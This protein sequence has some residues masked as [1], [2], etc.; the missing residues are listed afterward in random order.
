V[1]EVEDNTFK[2]ELDLACSKTLKTVL[3][4]INGVSFLQQKLGHNSYLVEIKEDRMTAKKI[5]PLCSY[6]FEISTEVINFY[7]EL[8]A[9]MTNNAERW[10]L[11]TLF[12]E[13]NKLQSFAQDYIEKKALSTPIS[14]QMVSNETKKYL[15]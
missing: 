13:L 14:T 2:I 4:D 6:V 1:I 3:V 7:M 10:C 12:G 5:G 9:A 8:N 15:G 11:C